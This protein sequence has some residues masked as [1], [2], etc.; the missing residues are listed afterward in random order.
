MKKAYF[1]NNGTHSLIMKSHTNYISVWDLV[2]NKNLEEI[3]FGENE[4]VKDIQYFDAL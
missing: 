1:T 4:F 3:R 2:N